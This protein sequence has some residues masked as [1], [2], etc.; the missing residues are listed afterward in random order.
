M[1]EQPAPHVPTYLVPLDGSRLAEAALPAA[2]SLAAHR[3]ARLLLLHVIERDAPQKVHGERHLSRIPEAISYLEQVATN[4]RAE[5]VETEVH[6]HEVGEYDVARSIYEHATEQHADL[7]ILCTH[8]KGGFRGFIF[9]S[10]AQQA[11]EHGARPLLLVRPDSG[12][13]NPSFA[14]RR[15]LVLLEGMGEVEPALAAATS[16]AHVYG[17]ELHLAVVVP[18]LGTLTGPQAVSGL[19]LPATMR[20]VLSLAEEGARKYLA[21]IEEQCRA[22]GLAVSCAVLRGDAVPEALA[23]AA[24][25]PADLVIAGAQGEAGLRGLLSGSTAKRMTDH[26]GAPILLVEATAGSAG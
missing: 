24:T 1:D 14:L 18:T 6:V 11:L 20:A 7:V 12:Q 5:G 19:Y 3:G 2:Q 8:G 21:R 4:L 25:L 15:I 9:G 10:I 22:E 13:T 26:A 16:L 23:L 17:A